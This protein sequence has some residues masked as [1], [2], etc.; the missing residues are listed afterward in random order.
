M[1]IRQIIGLVFIAV[2]VF[3]TVLGVLGIWGFVNE[4]T[5]GRLVGTAFVLA[6]GLGVAGTLLD[7]FF[8]EGEILREIT[9]LAKK[10]KKDGKG[11]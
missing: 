8:G 6:A 7:K 4:G 2:V 10:E 5:A 3:S 1:K 9:E 11:S